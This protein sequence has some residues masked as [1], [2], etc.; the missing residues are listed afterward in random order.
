MTPKPRFQIASSSL[1]TSVRAGAKVLTARGHIEEYVWGFDLDTVKRYVLLRGS[2][3][4]GSDW[5]TGFMTP[6]SKGFVQKSGAVEGGHCWLA[7]GYSKRLRAFRGLNSWG[8]WGQSGRFW[9]P[10]TVMATLLE[11]GAEA[12]S[13]IEKKV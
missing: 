4:M 9:I 12:A 7:N 5:Y 11:S 13:A 10:E 6:D 1:A 8:K 2:V 3:V